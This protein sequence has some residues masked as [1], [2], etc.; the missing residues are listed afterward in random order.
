MIRI[1]WRAKRVQNTQKNDGTNG[2]N[3]SGARKQKLSNLEERVCPIK[4]RVKG[5]E[6]GTVHHPKNERPR[7]WQSERGKYLPTN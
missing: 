7:E 2:A 6:R 1:G 4:V 5:L 3:L